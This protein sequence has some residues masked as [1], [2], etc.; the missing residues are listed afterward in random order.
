[1]SMKRS[2]SLVPGAAEDF[3]PVARAI[4]VFEGH[5]TNKAV[6]ATFDLPYNPRF[7]R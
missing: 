3:P 6:A 2:L 7:E 1:M 4:N 5:L